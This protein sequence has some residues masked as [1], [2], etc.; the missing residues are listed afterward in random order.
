MVTRAP[1][2][3]WVPPR[4]A[5]LV[6]AASDS[7]DRSKAQADYVCSGTNDEVQIQAAIDAVAASPGRGSVVLSEGTF[8]ISSTIIMKSYVS[9]FGS[10]LMATILSATSGT[11]LGDDGVQVS[12]IE[13]AHLELNGNA[14]AIWGISLNLDESIIHNVFTS[15]F[16]SGAAIYLKP[17][18]EEVIVA[19]CFIN[20]GNSSGIRADN[21]AVSLLIA[22]NY[23]WAIGNGTFETAN[24]K[25][26]DFTTAGRKGSVQ[27]IGNHIVASYGHGVYLSNVMEAVVEGNFFM[28]NRGNNVQ[29]FIYLEG[30]SNDNIIRGNMFNPLDRWGGG[31]G[32]YRPRYG[33]NISAATC[34]RN[35]I[36]GNTFINIAD[37]GTGLINDAGT[38]TSIVSNI[39]LAQ[40]KEKKYEY[41]KNTSG[42]ALEEGDLGVFKAVAAGDE[43]TTTAIQG[44]NMVY[45]MVAETIADNAWGLV[46]ILGKTTALKVNGITDIAIGD[47]IGTY[48]EAGIGMKAAAGDMAIAI[49]LEAY[50]TNDSSGV[51]D[52]LLITP[53]KI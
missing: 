43:F 26:N 32:T 10:G 42:G 46:Q 12:G 40:V 27:V 47:Y 9:L 11:L 51:I 53:R 7:L 41:L 1:Q 8:N 34:D 22:Y 37:F 17:G 21:V 36:V 52:A 14:S 20:G 15:T 39:P 50:A 48:T 13:I 44:D 33:I 23:I 2:G 30:D 6:V 38:L 25:L 19:G 16:S 18:S 28:S 29:D 5:T 49:A 45:G 31:G 35:M 24:I 4:T 3:I